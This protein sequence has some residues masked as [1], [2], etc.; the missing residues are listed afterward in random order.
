MQDHEPSDIVEETE[1]PFNM[2]SLWAKAYKIIQDD[3]NHSQLLDKFEAYLQ[4]A[5]DG[6]YPRFLIAMRSLTHD[7]WKRRDL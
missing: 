6:M 7:R 1:R 4:K 3:E 5:G 2:A